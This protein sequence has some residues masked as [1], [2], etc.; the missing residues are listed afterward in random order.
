MKKSTFV[1]MIMSL[2]VLASCSNSEPK[3]AEKEEA[4]AEKACTYSISK[5]NPVTLSWT[6]YKTMAKVGVGGKFTK[7]SFTKGQ[8][9]ASIA[10]N[11]K[12][13][14]F[15]ILTDSTDTGKPERDAK[16]VKYF[17]AKMADAQRISGSIKDAS[18][19]EQSGKA[20]FSI[21]LNGE[22][23]DANFTYKVGAETVVFEGEI[24]LNDWHAGEAVASLNEACKKLH[25]GDDGVSKTWP[26][27]SIKIEAGYSKVCK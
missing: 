27:V 13:R 1:L 12:G 6:A 16:I 11:I 2:F 15:K 9:A 26:N 19:D 22:E 3:T 25:T 8:P 21:R 17:W 7:F 20:T 14:E 5:A 10:E 24:D 4:T 23:H 18:G